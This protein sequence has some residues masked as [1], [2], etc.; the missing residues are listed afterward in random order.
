MLP[1]THLHCR[2]GD[3]EGTVLLFWSYYVAGYW[4]VMC[5]VASFQGLCCRY[6]EVT[7]SPAWQW[8][9]DR[10]CATC[11]TYYIVTVHCRIKRHFE[12]L[13]VSTW[14]N[15][16]II[17]KNTTALKFISQCGRCPQWKRPLPLVALTFRPCTCTLWLTPTAWRFNLS[18]NG[19]GS[20]ETVAVFQVQPTVRLYGNSQSSYHQFTYRT[21]NTL[22]QEGPD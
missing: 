5:F 10:V 20:K 13:I 17:E 14:G 9:F 4:Y 6:S 3:V 1:N 21:T 16:I 11:C 18:Q 19:P 22:S 7:F 8:I 2:Y 12:K 15:P